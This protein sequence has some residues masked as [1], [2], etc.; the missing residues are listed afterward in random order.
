MNPK[1]LWNYPSVPKQGYFIRYGN[2]A[3]PGEGRYRHLFCGLPPEGCP[4]CPNCEKPFYQLV[5]FDGSDPRLEGIHRLNLKHVPLIYCWRC[6]IAYDHFFYRIHADGKVE[7]LSF[8]AGFS[9]RSE[10]PNWPY[11]D[12]PYPDEFPERTAWL[13]PLSKSDS[14]LIVKINRDNMSP[15]DLNPL[16]RRLGK[17]QHQLGGKPYLVQGAIHLPPMCLDCRRQMPLFASIANGNG[18]LQGFTGEEFV[19]HL[20]HICPKCSVVAAYHTID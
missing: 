5:R 10:C 19:Q 7:V 15:W 2:K 11:E 4:P 20:F 17:I 16:T 14:E 18:Y 6:D 9:Q 8:K 3:P 13:K 12:K 1:A